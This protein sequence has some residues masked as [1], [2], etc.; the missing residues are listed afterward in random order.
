MQD[1][2]IGH[3]DTAGE[4]GVGERNNDVEGGRT[5][6]NGHRNKGRE[7]NVTDGN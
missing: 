1:E 4:G 2:Y 3:I 6:A 7:I 5:N